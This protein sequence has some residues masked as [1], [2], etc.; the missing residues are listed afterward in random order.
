MRRIVIIEDDADTVELLCVQLEMLGHDCRTAL[1]GRDGET[2]IEEF[3]P[4]AAIV[5]V[6]LP[7]IDGFEVARR[8]R[9]GN[10]TV[11]L[12]ALTG[13]SEPGDRARATTAGF[14]VFLVK[15]VTRGMLEQALLL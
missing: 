8:V 9:E 3:Q 1:S 14:D 10:R 12:V 15:P 7:D 6:G 2:L 4:D 11:R 5:D 13:R